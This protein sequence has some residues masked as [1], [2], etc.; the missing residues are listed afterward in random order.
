[1]SGAAVI[2]AALVTYLGVRAQARTS[3]QAAERTAQIEHSKVSLEAYED[4]KQTWRD[5]INDLREQLAELRGRVEE[6]GRQREVDLR[7]IEGLKLRLAALTVY[8]RM[9]SQL[10]RENGVD[11]PE[12]PQELT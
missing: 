2:G 3:A 5:N 9:L 7:T 12:P 6:Y 10:L 4:A 11:Y 8:T 1:M